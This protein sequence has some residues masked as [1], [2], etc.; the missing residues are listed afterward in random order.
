M[1]ETITSLIPSQI[2]HFPTTPSSVHIP[3]PSHPQQLAAQS[4][5]LIGHPITTKTAQHIRLVL[6]NPNGISSENNFF[7]YQLLLHHMK[8]VDTDIILLPET[9]LCWSRY[10]V[11][12]ST[13]KHRK[14][15]FH[16]SKQST[17]NSQ[18]SYESSYQPGGTASIITNNVVGR[19]HS[20]L[21]DDSLGRWSISNLTL[22][23][24]KL[25]SIIC[26]YQVCEQ[27][28]TSAG[29]KT[30]Y[31]QQWSIL[32]EKG[33]TH[34]NPRKQFYRDLD[35]TLSI[36]TKQGNLIILSGDFN[37]TIGE[38]P[39]GLDRIL[40]KYQ[41]ADPIRHSHGPY[42]CSTYSRGTKCIDYILVSHS[43]LPSVKRAGILPFDS[44]THSDH[45]PIFIDLD[46]HLSFGNSLA[47]LVTPPNRR[48][49]SSN[50]QRKDKYISHLFQLL[51]RHNVFAR[52]AK[53]NSFTSSTRDAVDLCE[54]IDRDVTRSMI[55]SEKQLRQPSAT[56]FSSTLAQACIKVSI[57]KYNILQLHHHSNKTAIIQRLQQKLATP[58]PLPSTISQS[59]IALRQA[60][61]VV[62]QIRKDAIAQRDIFLQAL[63]QQQPSNKLLKHIRRAEEMKQ[64]FA[65]IRYATKQKQHSLVSQLDI[66]ADNLPPKQSKEWKRITDPEQVT[67]CLI[68]RNT[69]HFGGA[70]GSPFTTCPI[71]SDFD[72]SLTNSH[73]QNTLNGSPP[74]YNRPLVDKLLL[75]LKQKVD[76]T[77]SELTVHDLVSRFRKWNEETTT[78]PSR[79]H[80]GHYKALLPSTNF[81]KQ[82]YV[83][84]PEGQILQVHLSLLNFC[85][86]TGYSLTRWHNIITTMIPK[87]AN[88]YKI[89]RLRVIHIYEADLTALFSIWS[90][91]MIRASTVSNSLNS[92][93]YGARPGRTS[94][95]PPFI[96]LLQNEL[97]AI[98]RTSLCIG[99]N[100]ASQCY[101]RL[102]PNQALLSCMS[103]GMSPS[104]AKCIGST[105]F[106][107]KY[108][109]RTPT[110][111]SLSYWS[112]SS[113]TPIYGTG[114][115]S[116]ISPGICCVVY[117]D[118]FDM[119]STISPV[120]IYT[121]P[122]N[123]L[124]VSI[125]NV[126]FVDDTTTTI[127]DHGRSHP[128]T[129]T[130][131]VTSL[132]SSLQSWANILHVSGGA[133]EMTKTSAYLL[134]W[135]FRENGT[136]FLSDT[137]HRTISLYRPDTRTQH[138]IP[139]TSPTQSF[140]IL[141]FHL[142]PNQDISTQYQVLLDKAHHLAISISNSSVNH[143]EAYLA[144]FSVFLPSI[145]YVFPLSTFSKTQCHRL[146]VLPTKL[147]L[148][149]CGFVS[150]MKRAIVFGSRLS[151]GL[152]FRHPYTEQGIA[153]LVKFIQA[154][155]TPGQTQ[156]L[157]LISIHEWQLNS[158][159]SYP[160]LEF[161]QR[162]CPHL[163]GQWLLSTRQFLSTIQGSITLTKSYTLSPLRE[164][165]CHIMDA[166][167]TT[168]KFSTKRMCRL[169]YCRLFLQVTL[170]S[171][172]VNSTGT[173]LL[174]EFWDGTGARPAPPLARYP[175]QG[176]PSPTVWS[177]WRA[178]IRKAFC[179]P[180]SRRL[181]HPLGKWY[182]S[183]YVSHR[184]HPSMPLSQC[185]LSPQL[186]WKS[187]LL[188]HVS[189]VI[190][191]KTLR[192]LIYHPTNPISL[193]CASDGGSTTTSAAFGWVICDGPRALVQCYGPVHG[194]QPTAYRAECYGA[195]SLLL[196]L[197]TL[198]SYPTH[199]GINIYIDNLS[200][201]RRMHQA[202]TTSLHSPST[203]VSPEQ[204]VLLQIEY[205]LSHIPVPLSLHHIKS[206]QDRQQAPSHLSYPARANCLADSLATKGLRTTT[207]L[208]RALP[209]DASQCQLNISNLT[210][211][212]RIPHHIRHFAHLQPLRN[213]IL[214]S[215][216]WSATNF[217]NWS[218]FGRLCLRHSHRTS[219]YLKWIHLILPTGTILH[220]RSSLESP[221]CPACGALETNDH[222]LL[223][224]H[225]SRRPL[226][227]SLM[228]SLR[229]HLSSYSI[230][231]TLANIL[232]DGV[233]SV[234]S[235]KPLQKSHYSSKYHSLIDHQSQ[236]GWLNFLR[237]FT[238]TEWVNIEHSSPTFTTANPSILTSLSSL[239]ESIY[240]LWSFRCTQ[241]HS[242]C[243]QQHD[244]ELRRQAQLL[245]T[246]LYS[247]RSLVLPTDRPIFHP[248]LS[249]HLSESTSN[250]R[251]WIANHQPYLRQSVLQA[252]QQ[253]ITHTR[254]ISSYFN[255][256]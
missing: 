42:Q 171:E 1:I 202:Q 65:K 68:D 201:V 199:V 223:C 235:G 15:V 227:I 82:E 147:F 39:T 136:P 27:H 31:H 175:R 130:A 184:L 250:L 60:R 256:S 193:I 144:Y 195:L 101:D 77:K 132:Q 79:R 63:I 93:S 180:R 146:Q 185:A 108:Y 158:G 172:I 131:L 16:F 190:S 174:S 128:S 40:I 41:L 13:N 7:E 125:S 38:D 113:S 179:H 72:W 233:D 237:G 4:N 151:G 145:S 191:T 204:D 177:E 66:P 155:R 12:S 106:N 209:F 238:T 251:A 124:Q 126:G 242:K 135:L 127:M 117:S 183:A 220:R 140:K 19:F 62:R 169:N 89:H 8:S 229:R 104:A 116:G 245:I 221:Y 234:F 61:Q 58:L 105:L 141:G 20:S 123:S 102:I 167:V 134:Y 64:G 119:H 246:Q 83:E 17:S 207:S 120:S 5:H 240:D 142:T 148:Q 81:N 98:T 2:P 34:P 186:S 224:D 192:H 231:P 100:D 43:L 208:S 109:L 11:I 159:M 219:F 206:H 205:Y 67:S 92:G 30:A 228:S 110:S 194:Y 211:T 139:L 118:L 252:Q 239:W 49:Y 70:H 143:R 243:L 247:L 75:H 78:S 122:D 51:S 71:S 47:N 103:H 197:S 178:A 163:E 198:C 91:R 129:P 28:I 50:P 253:H 189:S 165:D 173:H 33:H 9:N 168:T 150:T 25:L 57:L 244:S 249:T 241:R 55:S 255:S 73:Y 94:T 153:H 53:L 254:S 160:L 149:K 87:E 84:S 85:A 215:R 74:H 203:A 44:I 59:R 162:P 137:S 14:H 212:T 222:L 196:Y 35:H 6:Q 37:T 114:Q 225:P 248:C 214:Q 176:C 22:N 95:D 21:S 112:H 24:G 90:R 99:P 210:I 181:R 56:P 232:I 115:G 161:P 217:I 230:N 52:V 29:P 76:P 121:S 10:N 236:I 3:S 200:L 48:L 54:S 213:H 18:R 226:Y 170:L 218:F 96:S 152:G 166:L 164:H 23:N 138:T 188:Q 32:K 80:L 97:S 156:Q 182:S 86:R 111:Q 107:A 88:N 45:R 36:L 157:L 187:Q 69:S 133:L 216:P 154:L 46:P 26:C